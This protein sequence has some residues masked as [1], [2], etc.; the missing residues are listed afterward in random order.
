MTQIE[1]SVIAAV[2][3]S[4]AATI[5]LTALALSFKVYRDNHRHKRLEYTMQL[6][7]DWDDKTLSA[8]CHI[9]NYWE[10]Y[11]KGDTIPLTEIKEKRDMERRCI[12]GQKTPPEAPLITDH[13]A[14]LLNFMEAYAVAI[15]MG[16]ADER[17]LKASFHQTFNRWYTV[18]QEFIEEYDKQ[19]FRQQ[20]PWDQFR[21]MHGRWNPKQRPV[22]N[23]PGTLLKK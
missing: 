2:I 7:R 9:S 3:S 8:R 23:P 15:N 21:E 20:N 16:I 14:E 4:V 13:M 12:A 22:D 6:I 11:I 18:L 19:K 5:S 1:V 10:A 17:Y